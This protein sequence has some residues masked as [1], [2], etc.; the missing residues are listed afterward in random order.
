[1]NYIQEGHKVI[2]YKVYVDTLKIFFE[3]LVELSNEKKQEVK[4]LKQFRKEEKL[5]NR[6]FELMHIMNKSNKNNLQQLENKWKQNNLQ[7]LENKSNKN[8]LQQL[9]FE[10]ELEYLKK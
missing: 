1:L 5:K 6:L 8:N 7:Q 9:E 2:G 4:K 10:K 3:V